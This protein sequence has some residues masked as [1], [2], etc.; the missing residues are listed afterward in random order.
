MTSVG[1]S[2]ARRA[3]QRLA[4]A[5][6]PMDVVQSPEADVAA[7]LERLERLHQQDLAQR[8]HDGPLQDVIAALQDVVDLRA[9]E[10]VDLADVEDALRSAV[11][12]MRGASVDLYDDVE[13]NAGLAGALGRLA[14]AVE[15][16]GGPATEVHVAADASSE[17]DRFVVS[18]VRE[19]LHNVRKHAGAR[20][21]QVVVERTAPSLLRVAVRDDGVGLDEDTRRAAAGD[22]H[23]GLRSI[24]DRARHLGG[25]LH[26]AT[27]DEGTVVSVLL[28]AP[29]DRRRRRLPVSVE[30]RGSRRG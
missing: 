29:G 25:S 13:Q 5:L 17:H 12:G 20:Q 30:R 24:D 19:L 28:P 3:A 11:A 9:G 15:G 18:A 26:V 21:A 6:E 22:G 8:L 10:D 7:E 23:L 4:E 27:P 16:D 2:I 14:A 1:P